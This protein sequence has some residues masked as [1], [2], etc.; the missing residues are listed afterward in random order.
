M[1]L[2]HFGVTGT[3]RG[4]TRAQLNTTRLIIRQLFTVECALHHGD[5]VGVDEEVSL[6]VNEDG[7]IGHPPSN[8]KLRAYVI[9][10]MEHE[11]KPYYDR[12]RD[13]VNAADLMLALPETTQEQQQSGTWMTIRYARETGTPLF[14]INPDGSI[15]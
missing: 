2:K 3:R 14:I 10:V 8:D 11:P 1:N 4:G 13:I 9:N 6:M 7:R 12:N 15:A 5:C